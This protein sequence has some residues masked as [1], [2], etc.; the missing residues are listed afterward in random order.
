MAKPSFFLLKNCSLF[1]HFPSIFLLL[2]SSLSASAESIKIAVA[3]NFMSPMKE[4]ALVFEKSSGHAVSLSFGSSGKFYAQITN[5]APFDLFFSADQD[6]PQRLEK[7][8]IA[9]PGTRFTYAQG[10]LVLWSRTNSSVA[11]NS[12]NGNSQN[13]NSRA[14]SSEPSN[15]ERLKSGEYKKLALA[16][17]KLAPYGLA[18][19]QTLG[20]LGLLS[21]SRKHWVRGENISQ[22][23]QFVHT[24]NADIGFIALSQIVKKGGLDNGASWL[25]PG[26][27]YDPIRQ[28]AVLL[29]RGKNNTAAQQ[30]L[31]FIRSPVA[32]EIMTRYGYTF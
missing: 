18:A 7:Q 9:I 5:G 32:R 17:P 30:F 27:F 29:K 3:S 23:F 8:Q 1:R 28:D 25:V 13:S 22:T 2:L 24:G 16:N 6:K 26:T 15:L 19:R 14:S 4:I 11:N 31:E 20:N 12:Q 10:Q 21:S